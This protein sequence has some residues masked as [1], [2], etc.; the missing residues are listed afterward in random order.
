MPF[1]E[2]LNM[3]VVDEKLILNKLVVEN[4]KEYVLNHLAFEVGA[5][6]DEDMVDTLNGLIAKIET[7]S[8]DDWNEM[9]NYFPC[10]VP[11]SE[12]DFD[13]DMDED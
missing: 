4:T 6:L 2:D 12:K 5:V 7:L 8:D 1:P 11:Y 13:V 3:F 10:E 9:K